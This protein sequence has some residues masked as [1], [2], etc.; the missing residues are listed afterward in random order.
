MP[1]AKGTE[2]LKRHLFLQLLVFER[3]CDCAKKKGEMT[4]QKRKFKNCKK[5]EGWNYGRSVCVNSLPLAKMRLHC[6]ERRQS[7]PQNEGDC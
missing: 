6:R 2:E 4:K 1:V 3:G 7:W 5:K